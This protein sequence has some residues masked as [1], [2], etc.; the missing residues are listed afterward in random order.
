[1][2]LMCHRYKS[3]AGTRA[4]AAAAPT[5]P[6]GAPASSAPDIC[7]AAAAAEAARG[8]MHGSLSCLDTP[9]PRDP[10]DSASVSADLVLACE[11]G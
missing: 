8:D 7:M 3:C 6:A 11:A 9:S 2:P 10:P 4:A 1:M 5:A